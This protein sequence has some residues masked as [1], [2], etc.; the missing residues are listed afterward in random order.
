MN[1]MALLV[2]LSVCS[3]VRNILC[4]TDLRKNEMF[5][6]QTKLRLVY[7]TGIYYIWKLTPLQSFLSLNKSKCQ[8][9]KEEDSY[10]TITQL[11]SAHIRLSHPSE[12]AIPTKC[13]ERER[14]RERERENERERERIKMVKSYQQDSKLTGSTISFLVILT[15]ENEIPY[16]K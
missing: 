11:N 8:G 15:R 7:T 6:K 3:T 9:C 5:H 14:E 16:I 13:W 1:T 2:V 4:F 10:L 12:I